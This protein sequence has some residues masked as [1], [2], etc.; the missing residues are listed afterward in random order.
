MSYYYFY[1]N[2]VMGRTIE[3]SKYPGAF[4]TVQQVIPCILHLENQ[5]GEKIIKL[6]LL[7]GYNRE[8]ITR[9]EQE[10]LIA[11]FEAVVNSRVLGTA[12]RKSHWRLNT[13]K[14][15]DNKKVISDQS[16]PNM[17]VRKFLDH[18]AE[19]A[20]LCIIDEEQLA[21]WIEVI[22]L[23]INLVEFARKQ[24]NS[25]EEEIDEFQDLADEFF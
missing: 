21:K 17:H 23:W 7:E 12:H 6:L 18:F 14:D 10:K 11:N 15:K 5:C 20:E 19:L 4:I 2:N 13:G 1:S 16:M 25:T 8:N 22:S 24:C 3:A 9:S